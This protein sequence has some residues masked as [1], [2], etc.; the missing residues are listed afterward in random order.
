[1]W[2]REEARKGAH[3]MKGRTWPAEESLEKLDGPEEGEMGRVMHV[4]KVW[5]TMCREKRGEERSKQRGPRKCD[6]SCGET[7]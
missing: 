7:L 5:L 6:I 4:A 1:M 2:H 3:E